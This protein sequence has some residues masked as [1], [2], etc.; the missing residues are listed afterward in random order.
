MLDSV[1]YARDKY[2]V[3]GGLMFP[4][5]ATMYLAGIEDADYK[6]EKIGCKPPL[7]SSS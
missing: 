2:L 1:L 3:Q 4:D 5:Q 6:E 7:L